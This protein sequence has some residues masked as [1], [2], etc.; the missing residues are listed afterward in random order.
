MSTRI[1]NQPQIAIRTSYLVYV[2]EQLKYG[3][4]TLIIC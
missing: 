1:W 3:I 2:Y 4:G